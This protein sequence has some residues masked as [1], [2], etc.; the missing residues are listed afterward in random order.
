MSGLLEA[1]PKIIMGIFGV[2]FVVALALEARG[3][4]KRQNNTDDEDEK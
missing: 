4:W 3:V 1:L 2:L